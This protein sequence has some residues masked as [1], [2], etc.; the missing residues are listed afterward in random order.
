MRVEEK[1]LAL[2]TTR[3]DYRAEANEVIFSLSV[4]NQRLVSVASDGP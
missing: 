4:P 3:K 2:P 1:E